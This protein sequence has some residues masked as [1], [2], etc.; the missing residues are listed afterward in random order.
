MIVVECRYHWS[1]PDRS[2]GLNLDHPVM[3]Q[4]W[5]A[6]RSLAT[7]TMSAPSN[8]ATT[9]ELVSTKVGPTMISK[10]ST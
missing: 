7:I 8:A 6:G 5:G 9:S 3:Q 2:D 1:V 10:P 4:I